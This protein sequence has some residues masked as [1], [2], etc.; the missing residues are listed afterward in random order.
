MRS[1]TAR[2]TGAR[3]RC[4]AAAAT[5]SRSSP[6]WSTACPCTRS[7]A[8]GPPVRR[9]GP[10]GAAVPI[11]SSRGRAG[12]YRS[13]WQWPLRSP[14]RLVLVT[15]VVLGLAAGAAFLGN[16]VGGSARSGGLLADGAPPSSSARRAGHGSG[17]GSD[18]D[19][20]PARRPATPEELPTSAAPP[21]ALQTARA[22][23]AAWVNHPPGTT[24]QQWVAGMRAYTTDEYLGVLGAV[25]PANV[26]ASAVTGDAPRHPRVARAASRSRSRRTRCVCPCWW[27]TPASAGASP[28]TTGHELTPDPFPAAAAAAAPVRRHRPRA[29]AVPDRRVPRVQPEPR[30]PHAT[31]RHLRRRHRHGRA[32]LR[33]WRDDRDAQP[34]PAGERVRDHRGGQGA[35][36]PSPC[37]AGRARDRHAGV[38]P[39]QHQLRGPGLAGAVPAASLTGV[40]QPG[41]G[42]RPALQHGDLPGPAAGAARV[43][44][45]AG[46]GRRADRAALRVPGRVREVGEA[47]RPARR[48]G[49]RRV[50]RHRLRRRADRGAAAGRGGR[51]D[52]VRVARGRQALRVGRDRPGLLRLLRADA[53]RVPGRGHHAAAGVARPVQRGR[54]RPGPRGAAR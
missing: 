49:R 31:E 11:R 47:R 39:A 29:D 38:D 25:D 17:R 37:L 45:D 32:R 54:P 35:G 2:S 30:Q 36:R 23:A 51:G 27:S 26:P 15:V 6:S 8:R 22:W 44:A 14:L 18:A 19:G 9:T 46:H 41:A 3:T 52:R 53:A 48:A 10:P 16:K 24:N 4:R 42:H 33:R 43:G 34:G 5:R 21:E 20:A 13:L 7:T 1:T 40:G 50:R 28:A 12:A